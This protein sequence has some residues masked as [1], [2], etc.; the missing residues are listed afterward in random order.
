MRTEYKHNP[1]IPYSLH[2]MRVKKII[3][4]DKTIVLEFED[5]YEKLTEPFEQVEGNIT[6]EGVD[7]DCTC[8]ISL[9]FCPN[10]DFFQKSLTYT[11][12]S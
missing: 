8:V 2:D 3:I 10:L 5:G 1:P 11:F 7:F 4:Q 6:I 9:I 12:S